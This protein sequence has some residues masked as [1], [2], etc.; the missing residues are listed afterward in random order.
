MML[1]KSPGG[2]SGSRY[3]AIRAEEADR[4]KSRP[5]VANSLISHAPR[6]L[7]WFG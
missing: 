1:F 2:S 6:A 7:L 5:C 3:A 4:I